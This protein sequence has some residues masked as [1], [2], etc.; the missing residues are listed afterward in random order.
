MNKKK[1]NKEGQVDRYKARFV[2][3]G[4]S[5]QEGIDFTGT[6]ASTRRFKSCRLLIALAAA[7]NWELSHMDVQTAFLNADM[8]EYTW[9]NQ[10]D[11]KFMEKG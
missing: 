10:S 3:K 8:K 11:T 6:F 4:Y 9:N 5:Q 7:F 1:I 2:A